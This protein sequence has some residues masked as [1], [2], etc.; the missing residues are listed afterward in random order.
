M[1][2]ARDL[3]TVPVVHRQAVT[4]QRPVLHQTSHVPGQYPGCWATY[5]PMGCWT[6][7]VGRSTANPTA[8]LDGGIM[9]VLSERQVH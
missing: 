8:P 3:L 4:I 2:N 9:V 7:L 6:V 1:S 5:M